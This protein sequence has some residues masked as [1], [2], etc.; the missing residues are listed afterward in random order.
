MVVARDEDHDVRCGDKRLV[1]LLE[2]AAGSEG[3]DEAHLRRAVVREQVVVDAGEDGDAVAQLRL[4]VVVPEEAFVGHVAHH[5]DLLELL[6][7]EGKYAALVLEQH[8][9][10][11]GGL[12]GERP[13]LARLDRRGEAVVR[14]TVRDGVRRVEL[15]EAEA[16]EEAEIDVAV[17]LRLVEE[18]LLHR[19]ARVLRVDVAVAVHVAPGH[20]RHR[21]GS[22]L[23]DDAVLAH[24]VAHA[25][26]GARAEVVLLHRV[27]R[28]HPPLLALDVVDGAAVRDDES[29]EAERLAQERGQEERVGGGRREVD[30]VVRAHERGHVRA[31]HDVPVHARVVVADVRLA[32]VG[33][34]GAALVLVV[35]EGV[36]LDGRDGLEVLRVVALHAFDERAGEHARDE[37]IL[38][39]R[40]VRAAP[41]RMAGEVDRG[42]P[43]REPAPASALVERLVVSAALVGDRGGD[44]ADEL[45]VPRHGERKRHGEARALARAVLD[46]VQRL[47]PEVVAVHAEARYGLGVPAELVDLLLERHARDEVRRALLEGSRRVEIDGLGRAGPDGYCGDR[48]HCKDFRFHD[49]FR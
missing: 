39:P 9:T 36:V 24:V 19:L 31:R 11:G 28:R 25:L 23:G 10:A 20:E 5:D 46:S 35:V 30:G 16:R 29:R 4:A 49:V 8:H 14:R 41:E 7:V 15:A 34:R 26:P 32:R 42:T 44:G 43:V 6:R 40:L 13:V 18:A 48:R 38:A 3:R 27:A 12:F 1:R 37:R 21:D 33:R 45:F 47:V 22:G 17:D 2:R